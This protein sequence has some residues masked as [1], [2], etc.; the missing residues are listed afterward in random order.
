MRMILET[1][2]RYFPAEEREKPEDSKSRKAQ[3][4]GRIETGW[5]IQRFGWEGEE[6]RGQRLE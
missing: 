2:K 5:N 1:D 4:N 6:E 3:E